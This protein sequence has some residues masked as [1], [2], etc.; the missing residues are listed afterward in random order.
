MLRSVKFALHEADG[1]EGTDAEEDSRVVQSPTK[2]RGRGRPKKVV[3]IDQEVKP[4][5]SEQATSPQPSTDVIREKREKGGQEWR[6]ANMSEVEVRLD[7]RLIMPGKKD[8]PKPTGVLVNG[9][10]ETSPGS[11]T[12]ESSPK[13]EDEWPVDLTAGQHVLDISRKGNS[14]PWKVYLTVS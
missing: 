7:G 13:P 11:V 2:K 12:S 4:P 6:P 1:E 5:E 14:V 9:N 3:S 10:T 8:A